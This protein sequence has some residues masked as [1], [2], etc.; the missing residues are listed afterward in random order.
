[1]VKSF[2]ESLQG[3]TFEKQIQINAFL[4]ESQRSHK[5]SQ[6]NLKKLYLSLAF[7]HLCPAVPVPSGGSWGVNDQAGNTN[8]QGAGTACRAGIVQ[9]LMTNGK[10]YKLSHVFDEN[11]PHSVFATEPLVVSPNPTFCLD[12][13]NFAY[14]TNFCGHSES[15]SGEF[16]SEGTQ[17]DF[18]G[19]AGL[20]PMPSS[21]KSDTVFYNG[22]LAND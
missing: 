3:N 7:Q 12:T 17:L 11:S 14:D 20:R 19:H 21:P 5:I 8:T 22:F 18:F 4:S 1:N 13:S 10:S 9:S 6:Y 2:S 15:L 16:G